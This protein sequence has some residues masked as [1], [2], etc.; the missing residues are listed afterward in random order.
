ML[1]IA[2]TDLQHGCRQ[3]KVQNLNMEVTERKIVDT[4][5]T[6]D[7]SYFTNGDNDELIITS[8]AA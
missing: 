5:L 2:V 4:Q 6:Y 7:Q 3:F 1:Q 8:S